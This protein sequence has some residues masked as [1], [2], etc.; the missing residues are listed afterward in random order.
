MDASTVVYWRQSITSWIKKEAATKPLSWAGAK[1]A[2][3]SI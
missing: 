1:G 3:Q 2:L